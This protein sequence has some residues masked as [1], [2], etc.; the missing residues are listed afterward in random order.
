MDALTRFAYGKSADN[1]RE[2]KMNAVTKFSYEI[3]NVH[4]NSRHPGYVYA[5]L[6]DSTGLLLAA[7]LGIC[8]DRLSGYVKMQT[9]NNCF[10]ST[11][12]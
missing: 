8:V 2:E 6:H 10:N 5:E 12:D 7:T 9:S 11:R 3:K 4:T 1:M